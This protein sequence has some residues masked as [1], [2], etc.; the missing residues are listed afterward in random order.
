MVDDLKDEE[1]SRWSNLIIRNK[2]ENLEEIYFIIAP[3]FH[4]TPPQSHP[5]E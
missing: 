2:T 4:T 5:Q 1:V 3:F